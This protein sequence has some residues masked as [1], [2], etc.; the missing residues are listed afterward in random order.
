MTKM[1]QDWLIHASKPFT[2]YYGFTHKLT[3]TNVFCFI[4]HQSSVV[5][6]FQQNSQTL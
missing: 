5:E 6:F 4:V 3:Y 1:M 2:Q